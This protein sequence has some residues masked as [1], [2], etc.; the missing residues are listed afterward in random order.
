MELSKRSFLCGRWSSGPRIEASCLNKLGV[1]CEHCREVCEVGAVRF[2]YAVGKLAYPVIEP[3]ACT[4]CGDCVTACP[5]DAI[6][7][8]SE[9][10]S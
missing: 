8:V 1:Y 5:A 2:A 9:R 6:S 7:V 10:A 4:R 3:D